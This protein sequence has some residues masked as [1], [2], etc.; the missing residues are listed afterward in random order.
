MHYLRLYIV[1]AGL[2]ATL[3]AA[4]QAHCA[5]AETYAMPLV[6]LQ[7]FAETELDITI[8][9]KLDEPLWQ[10]LPFYDRMRIIFPDTMVAAPH[11]TRT[12][13]F[14]TE[15]GLYV[16]IWAEQPVDTLIAR[17]SPRDKFVSRDRVRVFIDPSGEGLYGY[18]F[19][20]ALGGTLS[21]GTVLPERQLR[22]QWDGPWRGAIEPHAEG[23]AA[24]FFLPWS[25]MAMPEIAGD[26]R[27]IGFY[28]ERG[29]PARRERWSWPALPQS[30]NRFMTAL[31]PLEVSNF[32]PRKQFTFYPYASTTYDVIASEDDYK[33]G[34]DVFWRPSSNL[35]LTATVNPDFG[36]VESDD[37]VVNLTSF[38]TFFPEKRP[39]FLEGQ[40]IFTTTP[41][42]TPRRFGGGTPTML[43]NTRRIGSP[44]KT[45]PIAGFEL[46]DLERNQPTELVGA[47]KV[48][49][50]KGAWRYGAF[51]A[52]EDDTKLEG[53]LD[54]VDVDLKQ[55]GRDFGV[56]RF[57]YETTDGG[58]RRGLGWITTLVSHPQEDAIVHGIDGHY[59]SDGGRWQV[60]GHLL[61]SDVDDVTGSGGFVDVEYVPKQGTKHKFTFDYYDD[62]I[63]IND[64]GF[65]RRNDM[66][67]TSYRLQKTNSNVEGLKFRETSVN[68]SQ[69][70]NTD[71]RLVRTGM[72][73][74]QERLFKNN[75]FLFT[76]VSYRP[77]RWDDINSDGNGTYEVDGRWQA[78]FYTETDNAKPLAVG[79]GM[80]AEQ[81]LVGGVGRFTEIELNWRPNDRF[82]TSF[83]LSYETQSDW[84]IHWGG[85][86]F[87][88]FESDFWQPRLSVD[89]FLS[90]KQ[91]FRLSAQW[92]GI[93]A[94]EK[95]R[96]LVPLKDGSLLRGDPAT[97][98]EDFSIST[99]VFQARY[100]WEIAPL[101][102][103]FV[104]YTRGSDLPNQVDDSFST[105]LRDSWTDRA[106][107][108][109]VVKLRYR[110]G[111]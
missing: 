9:G 24:E 12:R 22:E 26:K 19:E 30:A 63:D 42:A 31:Q 103:L 86:E 89:F 85:R 104:V 16:G 6:S 101:S 80:F 14:Y 55:T 60:D 105:L 47:A 43:V 65:L 56:A 108:V 54:G 93:K 27:K 18:W 70:Y 53:L 1:T 36:N 94:R 88:T 21:D 3:L 20:L 52:L 45:L 82:A 17:L 10:Q 109:F 84:L 90:A 49:G 38:E 107:D 110:L 32:E 75:Q 39:F 2:L 11:E 67:G 15:R 40:E 73:F 100:R 69:Q 4:P 71:G 98:S 77:S 91:Q 106:V 35:Q 23:F 81:G 33:A 97:G 68:F 96:Y 99:L 29:L 41:R 48:T 66:I 74:N 13:L 62:E 8:D 58:A 87:I 76:E 59:I 51:A 57:L 83:W 7:E 92:V 34:F 50:Q 95:K 102:D 72:F 28:V 25:M 78:G 46:T 61:Y 64:F 37:V 79:F 44:P 111:S 5:E